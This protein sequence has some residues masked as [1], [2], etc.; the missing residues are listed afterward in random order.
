MELK[1]IYR[2]YE[3]PRVTK[4]AVSF[5][6]A[7][8]LG[9]MLHGKAASGNAVNDVPEPSILTSTSN[10]ITSNEVAMKALTNITH[11]LTLKFLFN[12]KFVHWWSNYRRGSL[13]ASLKKRR[14]TMKKMTKVQN[15]SRPSSLGRLSRS[16]SG[17]LTRDIQCVWTS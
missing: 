10:G 16:G 12:K 14:R 3:T 2:W 15:L 11:P 8:R 17:E 6:I 5:D 13:K 9:H 1:R 4:N 7:Q